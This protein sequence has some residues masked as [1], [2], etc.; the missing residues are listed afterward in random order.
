LQGHPE[1][2]PLNI[3]SAITANEISA[4]RRCRHLICFGNTLSGNFKNYDL[5]AYRQAGFTISLFIYSPARQLTNSPTH[6]LAS[7]PTRQLA[8]SP[9]HQLAS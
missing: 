5:P 7:S 6:Q 9:T 4:E 1:F 2:M 8:S 3:F